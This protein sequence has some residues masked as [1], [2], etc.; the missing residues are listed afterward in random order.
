MRALLAA[1]LF[2]VVAL[3]SVSA[4]PEAAVPFDEAALERQSAQDYD[5][6]D[7]ARR[8]DVPVRLYWPRSAAAEGAAAPP[9]P[10]V[11]FSHGIGGSRLGYSYFGRFLAA[12]GIAS[13]HV[14]HIGSDRQV[15][16]GNLLLLLFRLHSAAQESEAIARVHDLRFALDQLMAGPLGARI[17]KS[18]IVVAGHSYGANTAMLAVGAQF[19]RGGRWVSFRDPRYTAAVLISAP[20]FYGEGDAA[21]ILR[22]IDVPTLHVTATEDEI[23]IP[24]YR[25]GVEDRLAVFDAMGS[26]RK[27][28]AMFEGGSHSIF[29]DRAVTGGAE[30]NPKVKSA[31]RELALAFLQRVFDGDQAAMERWGE[32]W[33]AILARYVRKD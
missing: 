23:T 11:V 26:R 21:S 1:A 15:W 2:G 17:D 22:A 28:L 32:R 14:Q 12:Q 33:K 19:E 25:S 27:A 18:R 3:G 8:R 10:L 13:L 31:T 7:A 29:T 24:G 5:W 20:P 30:L 9:V 16:T 6:T 4:A